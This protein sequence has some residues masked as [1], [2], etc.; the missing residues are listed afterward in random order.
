LALGAESWRLPADSVR[1]VRM[2]SSGAFIDVVAFDELIERGGAESLEAAIRLHRGPL[3]EDCSDEW[4]IQDR[5]RR[6]DA[7]MSALQSLSIDAEERGD[8]IEAARYLRLAVTADPLRED[9]QRGLMHALDSA[10]E[11]SSAIAVF[12]ELRGLLWSE[13]ATAPAAETTE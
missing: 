4:C 6:E 1:T 13:M 9:L 3:L 2:D 7:Y 11:T 5:R 8:Y 10:G 12:R